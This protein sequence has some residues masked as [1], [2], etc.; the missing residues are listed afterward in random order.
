MNMKI[1]GWIL[2][3]LGCMLCF[4]ALIQ[5]VDGELS[6]EGGVGFVAVALCIT[7]LVSGLIILYSNNFHRIRTAKERTLQVGVG[8]FFII[9][10]IGSLLRG[11]SMGKMGVSL[12]GFI[13]I[14]L[15]IWMV[16]PP[17]EQPDT[18]KED[19]N[20]YHRSVRCFGG[21][22][23]ISCSDCSHIENIGSRKYQCQSCG[24]FHTL[25]DLEVSNKSCTCPCGGE[26]NREKQIFCP[27][28]KSKNVG[29]CI[30]EPCEPY[31]LPF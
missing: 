30:V 2:T 12:F 23:Y 1:I 7:V 4:G 10:G 25:N 24:R 29:D 26:L 18:Q 15:G 20:K 11:Q 19:N 3:V 31:E 28:C 22:G 6:L 13:I 16:L 9:L 17:N 27:Q 21:T 8:W 14:M 5:L